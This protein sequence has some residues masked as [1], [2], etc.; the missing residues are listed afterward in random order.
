MALGFVMLW[1]TVLFIINTAVAFG[2]VDVKESG[3]WN[4]VLGGLL[5]FVVLNGV[6]HESFGE[7]TFYWAAQVLL[8]AITY[9]MMG[10]NIVKAFDSRGLGWYCLFVS[11]TALVPCAQTFLAGDFVLGLIWAV[12]VSLWFLFF[13]LLALGKAGLGAFLKWYQIFALV[14]SLWL[15]GLLLLNGV[16]GT[17]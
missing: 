3:P 4:I 8:F 6:F 2:K 9:V 11:I 10:I 7:E 1:V 5:V 17:W 13:L 16:W 15:P 12:W 14:F